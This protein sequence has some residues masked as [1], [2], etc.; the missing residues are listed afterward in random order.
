MAR[1]VQSRGWLNVVMRTGGNTGEG[2]LMKSF[3]GRARGIALGAL[4]FVMLAGAAVGQGVQPLESP[5][6]SAPSAPAAPAAEAQGWV[7]VPLNTPPG[8]D[9]VY[10]R[11][12]RFDPKTNRIIRPAKILRYE[13]MRAHGEE[14]A[15]DDI[16]T[17]AEYAPAV[18]ARDLLP[19]PVSAGPRTGS[20]RAQPVLNRK[21][22][23]PSINQGPGN[24]K[25]LVIAYTGGTTVGASN[26]PR[27]TQEWQSAL[28][29][30]STWGDR[31]QPALRPEV[32][33]GTIR[34]WNK[35]TPFFSYNGNSRWMNY[36]AI[37]AENGVCGLVNS[38]A[39]DAVVVW[40]ASDA[41]NNRENA[42]MTGDPNTGWSFDAIPVC[43]TEATNP[44]SAFFFAY[45]TCPGD[46][47]E[48]GACSP[49]GSYAPY[50]SDN[51]IHSF[52]HW[53]ETRFKKMP[54]TKCDFLASNGP[55]PSTPDDTPYVMPGCASH[56]ANGFIAT[57]KYYLGGVTYTRA[58]AVC[59]DVHFPPNTN[60][61][62]STGGNGYRYDLTQSITT[63]C[64]DWQI[65]AAAT[66]QTINCTAWGCN[67]GNFYIWWMKGIPGKGNN[68]REASGFVGRNWWEEGLVI[69]PSETV[70]GF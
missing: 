32:I 5:I 59:G 49:P 58:S 47:P 62:R 63:Q 15:A 9:V 70:Y 7:D 11:G 25:V 60:V 36:S 27:L 34:T 41:K 67:E 46:N 8:E 19:G 28:Q 53:L 64:R 23:L 45:A 69:P 2:L 42:F 52:T 21:T 29:Q 4:S 17:A 56:P 12:T 6:L 43:G 31:S 37:W 22:F 50:G 1:K 66:T 68:H 14:L 24:W 65:G 51:A 57:Q 18:K 3:W 10:P 30:G 55:E 40:N 38:G 20:V 44:Y 54:A 33:S 39:I 61:P 35:M 13:Q 48:D 16:P 26:I